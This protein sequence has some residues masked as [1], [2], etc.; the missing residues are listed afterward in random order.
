MAYDRGTANLLISLKLGGLLVLL[1]IIYNWLAMNTLGSVLF[2]LLTQASFFPSSSAVASVTDTFWLVGRNKTLKRCLL[3]FSAHHKLECSATTWQRGSLL[4]DEK[5]C[6]I[7]MLFIL[8]R[9][10]NKLVRWVG[11]CPWSSTVLARLLT[12]S[13]AV[14]R[15]NSI[16]QR[17]DFN[18]LLILVLIG[19]RLGA[20]ACNRAPIK[21]RQ[22]LWQV[23]VKQMCPV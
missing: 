22:H 16:F 4:G 15:G 3:C 19:R 11:L 9:I 14:P 2:F 18:G 7:L 6:L 12:A 20:K 23:W 13:M 10:W 1:L 17:V 21:L 5:C 8:L